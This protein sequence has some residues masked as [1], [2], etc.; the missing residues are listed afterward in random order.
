MKTLLDLLKS[1]PK[2]NT[3]PYR[4][5]A[6]T[7]YPL[8]EEQIREW[9]R[10]IMPKKMNADYDIYCKGYDDAIDELHDKLLE[11]VNGR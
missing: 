5:I 8:W 11:A 9:V 7:D 10:G 1:P 4:A 6:I 2:K 3:F